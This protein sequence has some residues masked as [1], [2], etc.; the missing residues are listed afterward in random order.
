MKIINE[1]PPNYAQ[2]VQYLGSV[3]DSKPFFA[4]GDTIYN[5]FKQEI[6]KDFEIHEETHSKQQGGNPHNWW[7]KYL[8]EPEFRLEQEIEA[9]GTQ[10]AY[11]KTIAN[12]K[13][14]DW[15]KENFAKA[16]SGPLYGN[17]LTYHQAESRINRY[18][19]EYEKNN[20]K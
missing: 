7:Y 4:Y 13:I 18:A 9:Y 11:V 14:T 8:T 2:V 5:P 12:R 16:L 20:S 17:L 6:T 3:E 19:K 10:Y 15:L 1:Y